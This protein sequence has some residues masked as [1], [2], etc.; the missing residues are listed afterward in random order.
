MKK[1]EEHLNNFEFAVDDFINSLRDDVERNGFKK[2]HKDIIDELK[3]IINS[4]KSKLLGVGK[5]DW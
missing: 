1:G 4:S 5:L 2:K 3:Y